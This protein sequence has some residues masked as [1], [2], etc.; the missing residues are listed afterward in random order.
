MLKK[1]TIY[2][3][4]CSGTNYLENII[5]INF[6]AHLT[7]EY[8]HKHFFGFQDD[9]LKNSDDTLFIC[10][11]R[12]LPDWINS[13]FRQKHHLPLLYKEKLSYEEKLDVFLNKEFWSFDDHNGNRD[14]TK[15]IM[16]DRNI[17]TGKRYKN[18]YELRHTKLKWMLEDLPN[19][20]KNY[21]FI[22]YED[23]INDF[24]KTL[25]KIKDKG[26]E[27]KKNINFP[28]N[29]DN[30]KNN[31]KKKFKRKKNNISNEF[32]LNNPNLIT[33]YEKK[34]YYYITKRCILTKILKILDNTLS[35]YNFLLTTR[36]LSKWLT[37][38]PWIEATL[39]QKYALA[40]ITDPYL[41][42]FKGIIPTIF[43]F[44][45]TSILALIL[46]NFTQNLITNLQYVSIGEVGVENIT[47]H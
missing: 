47:Q 1:Y 17:Y 16:E 33:F 26:L 45:L 28:L 2:G 3:E 6:D 40:S 30:Y 46:L 41:K 27:V 12:N 20:V 22:R 38:F 35:I 44:D 29:T 13:F 19:K 9:A 37:E 34:I 21:I 24:D 11:V 32:I 25:L 10:I 31:N 42:L 8:G 7:W 15:E 4:R 36:I 39:I 5:N 14:T 43:G 18:I 23:L